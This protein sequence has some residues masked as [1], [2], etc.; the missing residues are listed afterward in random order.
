MSV[1]MINVNN[2]GKYN[3]DLYVR[4]NSDVIKAYNSNV[5]D[6][7]LTYN[8]NLN[9]DVFEKTEAPKTSNNEIK[10]LKK[11]YKKAQDEQGIIGR[12]A[13]KI[14]NFFH[15]KN[16]SNNIKKAIDNLDENSS[17][18]EIQ[19]VKEKLNKYS[20][21]QESAVKGTATT[22]AMLAGG[23]AGAKVG[24]LLGSVVPGIGNAV[25]LAVGAVAGA[26]VGAVTSVFVHQ[27]ENM[28]DN[29]KGNSWQNDKNLLKEAGEGALSGG[30]AV[31]MGGITQKLTGSL[32]SKFGLTA[33]ENGGKTAFVALAKDGTAKV[34]ATVA[35]NAAVGAIA[36]GTSAAVIAD[37]QY[38]LECAVDKD[39]KFSLTDFGTTTL[40]SFG[41]GGVMG[42]LTGGVQGYKGATGYNYQ[43]QL[44]AEAQARMQAE[45]EAKVRAQQAQEQYNKPFEEKLSNKSAE[46]SAKAFEQSGKT[47]SEISLDKKLKDFEARINDGTLQ[48][49]NNEEAIKAYE[50]LLNRTKDVNSLL[51]EESINS[52]QLPQILE[53]D[54]SITRIGEKGIDGFHVQ[55]G[56]QRFLEL[57]E[58]QNGTQVDATE[59]FMKYVTQNP[60]KRGNYKDVK[61]MLE[62]LGENQDKNKIVRL[63][64]IKPNTE[65]VQ[66]DMTYN[67]N[68]TINFTATKGSKIKE[69]VKTVVSQEELEHVINTLKNP[70]TISRATTNDVT[71]GFAIM[72]NGNFYTG[73]VGDNGLVNSV[74]PILRQALID[75]KFVIQL[76]PILK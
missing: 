13:D 66:I 70:T 6:K 47:S 72:Y 42:G 12:A 33:V 20:S 65:P 1:N 4:N 3:Y 22:G 17:P 27:A 34:G 10:E 45:A 68:N 23:A 46:E 58:Q 21:N 24:A 37:G 71:K 63:T 28:T 40:T 67:Q 43:A 52:E 55:E 25:G 19:A 48:F 14:K 8:H 44:K 39:K 26:A 36:S 60:D 49:E 9:S 5:S 62:Y 41:I 59:E 18:E 35:K 11:A 38:A 30:S 76:I 61:V 50:N 16:C 7:N 32:A 51:T 69:G 74:Y 56:Y 53:H 2:K 54:L 15:T 31:L 73:Q 29:V 57:A 64:R 75:R